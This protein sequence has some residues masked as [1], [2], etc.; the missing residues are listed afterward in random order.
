MQ[1]KPSSK[2]I[3][4]MLLV[5]TIL[6]ANACETFY[7]RHNY[8]TVNE[9]L[10][11]SGDLETKPFLKAHLKNGEVYI[12]KDSWVVDTIQQKIVVNGTR[13]DFNRN[14]LSNGFQSISIDSIAIFETNIKL[15]AP[16]SNRIAALGLLTALDAA[17][18]IFCLSNPKSCFGSC[19]TFY[20]NENDNFHFAD[21]EGFSNAI[22]PSLEYTDI[23]A[24]NTQ[25]MKSNSF[26]LTMKNEALE[27]HCVKQVQLL[28][29][30]IKEN[31]HV[32]QTATNDFYLSNHIRHLSKASANEGDVTKL[33][34]ANDREERF[35]SSDP[36][37]LN[38]KE[39]IYLQF[40]E[41]NTSKDLGLILHFR[42][43]MMTTYFIYS[44]MGYM[45]DEVGDCF[46][47]IESDKGTYK[48]LEGGIKKV[49]GD[50]DV[51]QWNE[52]MNK[53][54]WQSSIYETGPI[55]INQQFIPLKNKSSNGTTKLKLIIN[56]GLW[57]IDYT[58]LSEIIKQVSPVYIEPDSVFKK[59]TYDATS[60]SLLNDPERYL[61]SMPGSAYKMHF[62][63]PNN[64]QQ[65]ELFLSS[66]GYYLEWMRKHW[67]KDKDMLKLNSMLNHPEQFLKDEAAN[68]KMYETQIERS[69]W[70]SKI[71]SKTFSYD[72]K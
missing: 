9:T 39:E 46:A 2:S 30:P 18:G 15:E 26:H 50:I 32:Y 1:I 66:K 27:T 21:A 56:K 22:S 7:F 47:K 49:L 38:S 53:W 13:Y 59:G 44:A 43:S 11:A 55:A 62:T 57:R 41:V 65:Y 52:A 45:G 64:Q 34:K 6:L 61:I 24:I 5:F 68:Y 71:D 60:T 35:S 19:P 3:F 12:L 25:S 36:I 10:H 67:L 51:Y 37:N 42:Q 31:E 29:F 72:E 40:D 70:E 23:D 20:I 69:F 54:E 14:T 8:R 58:A 48:K 33:L 16:E 17:L 28:A 4:W 63:L